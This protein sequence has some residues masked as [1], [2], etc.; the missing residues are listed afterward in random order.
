[1]EIEDQKG[2]NIR[3]G[4]GWYR[5]NTELNQRNLA[6]VNTSLGEK[7]GAVIIARQDDSSVS[8]RLM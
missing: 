4:W 3:K 7:A 5:N 1:M 8:L 2:G 6:E